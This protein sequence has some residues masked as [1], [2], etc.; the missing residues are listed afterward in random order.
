MTGSV[1][2]ILV[3]FVYVL[4]C[5]FF[6]WYINLDKYLALF[7]FITSLYNILHVLIISGVLTV[8]GGT[9]MRNMGGAT[10]KMKISSSDNVKGQWGLR[11][12]KKTEF[13]VFSIVIQMS[14]L[15]LK[16]IYLIRRRNRLHLSTECMINA[17]W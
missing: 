11:W 13:L 14:E 4:W 12:R 3:A 8:K 9:G 10:T 15:M 7:Y 6:I 17:L 2:L 5:M 1:D 16:I